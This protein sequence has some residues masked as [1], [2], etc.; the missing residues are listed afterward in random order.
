MI[1]NE[2]Y[3]PKS[4]KRIKMKADVTLAAIFIPPKS[5]GL[6]RDYARD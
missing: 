6:M 3:K 1:L 2:N 5:K 4:G